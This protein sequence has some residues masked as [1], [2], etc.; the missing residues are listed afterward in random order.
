[1]NYHA[2][3]EEELFKL[4]NT[5][6]HGL[7][8]EEAD[9]RIEKYGKNIIEDNSGIS[10]IK[11]MLQQFNSIII[12][13][14][15]A[16]TILS[17]FIGNLV[18][19]AII[20][21]VILVNVLI[22]FFQQYRAEKAIL[23]LKKM[24]IPHATVFRNG[25]LLRISST[26]LV[27]G[28]ILSLGEGDKIP[29]DCRIIKTEDLEVNEAI[30]TG[31]SLTVLKDNKELDEN[32]SLAERK[33]ML[34]AGTTIV[35]GNCKCL[36]VST[37]MNTEFG[38]I[39][40]ILKTLTPE[41][42]VM[43]KKLDKF[44]KQI[45]IFS[46]ILSAF[47]LVIGLWFGLDKFEM[48]LTGVALAVSAIPEGLPAVITI[49]LA[50]A[51]RNMS[52]KN[53]IT[54]KLGAAESL[55]D[56]TVI[57]TDKTGTITEEKMKVKEIFCDN[58]FIN[59][60]DEGLFIKNAQVNLS[61]NKEAFKLLRAS[62]L[63]NNARF[64]VKQ[65][66]DGKIEEDYEILGDPTE[67][68]LVLSALELGINKKILTEEEK[69]VKEIS[70]SSNRKMMS[71]I[72][73]NGRIKT[74]Y[75]KGA[76]SVILERC[77]SELFNNQIRKITK[78]RRA[79]LKETYEKMEEKALRVLG[80][81]YKN[82][83]ND[84]LEETGLIFLGFIGMQDIPRPEVFQA[85][86]ACK[87]AG[88]KIKMITGDSMITAREIAKQVGIH[89]DIIS[90]Q[91]LEKMSDEAL[92][93]NIE[94]ISIFARTTPEQKLRIVEILR[95]KGEIVAITGDGVND[96]LAL[97]KADIGIAMGI[98]G[99][100]V[101]REVSDMILV[102]DNFASIVKAV[103]EGRTV[104]DNIKRIT[105]FLVAVNFSQLFLISFAIL[106][107]LPLPLLPI[108][109]LWMNLIT[110]SIPSL[111][112][113]NEKNEVMNRGPKKEKSILDGIFGFVIIAGLVCFLAEFALFL[114]GMSMKLDISHIRT[115]VLTSDV[116][117]ELL[118][119]YACKSD[120]SIIKKNILSNKF[121]N[122]AVIISILLQIAI[123]YTPL[124]TLFQLSPLT[125]TEWLI[126]LPFSLSG[127]VIFEVW[128]LFKK[129]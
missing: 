38:K 9:K 83:N 85:I 105:K 29:S 27:P 63:C 98:R 37:G 113:L 58:Q 32:V 41:K 55:G 49:G 52:K 8:K 79:Q 109:I 50:F 30:L 61:N 121:L 104:Y 59:K 34:Y 90:G 43:Q 101:S 100:D 16:A 56:V 93:N 40:G 5:S 23:E 111:A 4:F 20:A 21:I 18:D 76:P 10:K 57:C 89:G 82:M 28:D 88:I 7:T 33:N 45:T 39:A 2:I 11:I 129:N 53:V 74:M 115:M 70:F 125:G 84:K 35:K 51:A 118:F 80:F 99:S 78:E 112:L 127:L 26:E 12:Y 102:D 123:V 73:D 91:E 92:I 77:N 24:L 69:R 22:G 120:L 97:K 48:I 119:V 114:L 72:R 75:S 47:V 17:Y 110:D 3:K 46:I 122:Y 107:N 1:M 103:E 14:L 15:I 31:E 25:K 62:V 42:T 68:A 116:I 106:M 128:K 13:V 87:N 36:V 108:H 71:I 86:E 126:L 60:K 67:A 124:A 95:L 117:F 94:R 19:A 81:A 64:E 6:E 54:R 44:A 66:I 65:R 96:S